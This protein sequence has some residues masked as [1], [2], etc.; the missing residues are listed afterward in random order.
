MLGASF[1]AEGLKLRRRP[2]VWMLGL[3]WLFFVVV[4]GY[5]VVYTSLASIPPAPLP[6]DMPAAEKERIRE[7][8]RRFQEDQLASLLPER[9]ASGAL[10]GFTQ[11]GGAVALFLGAMTAG[12]E[13]NWGTLKTLLTQRPGRPEVFG[14]KLLAL[15]VALLALLFAVFAGS[16]GAS[17]AIAILE[18]IPADWPPVGELARAFGAGAL[19]MTLWSAFGV[20]LATLFRGTALAVGLG[21][22]YLLV[23]EGVFLSLPIPGETF[24]NV[25]ELFPGQNSAF[26]ADNFVRGAFAPPDPPVDAP[27]AALVVAVY[28]ALFV[29]LALLLFRRRDV[30]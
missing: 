7:Q 15:W 16:A 30:S 23:L 24:R 18:E 26:L 2:G 14:G 11:L 17:Y 3:V 13:Y 1:R 22:V 4:V 8:D 27:Q 20:L 25:R 21:L 12:S 9:L 10:S 29:L 5:F 28:A 6:E 19:I